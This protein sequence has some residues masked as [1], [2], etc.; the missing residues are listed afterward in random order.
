MYFRFYIVFLSTDECELEEQGIIYGGSYSDA[1]YNLEKEYSDLVVRAELEYIGS[2]II[3]F[4]QIQA[5][6]WKIL[7][8][9]DESCDSCRVPCKMASI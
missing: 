7:E 9:P 6:G 8:K 1:M 5:L 4:E 2:G 3:N